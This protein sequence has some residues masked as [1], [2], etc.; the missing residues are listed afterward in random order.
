MTNSG[1][2]IV[3]V[4]HSWQYPAI[5]EYHAFKKVRE[6]CPARNGVVYFAFPWATLIDRIDKG[7]KDKDELLE[8]L[9]SFKEELAKFDVV[10]SVCQ[11]IRMLKHLY[12]FK[13]VGITTV[14]WSHATIS[15]LSPAVDEGVDILPFPLYPTQVAYETPAWE[16]KKY[17]FSFVGA[18]ANKWYLTESR[19]IIIDC[20]SDS[21]GGLVIG[22]DSWH[23]NNVVYKTQIKGEEQTKEEIEQEKNRSE[24]YLQVML[25]TKYALCPSGSGPN[26]IRLWECV[27][28][29]VVPVILADDY[30]VPGDISLWKSAAFFI[31]EDKASIEQLP[32]TLAKSDSK[33]LYEDKL[34]ALRL[35]KFKYGRSSFI[36]DIISFVLEI[37]APLGDSAYALLASKVTGRS[38]AD[39]HFMLISLVSY[40]FNHSQPIEQGLGVLTRMGFSLP[41]GVYDLETLTNYLK[42]NE[43]SE[44]LS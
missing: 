43:N 8:E 27:E 30:K 12:L 16:E 10:I 2:R 11:H 32:E 21:K 13:D 19:N 39:L 25:D 4:D 37:P 28:M 15:S 5:T 23:Y 7:A 6:L 14:F 24:E 9:Y 44:V 29:G 40:Y 36:T 31:G 3:G 33:D 41:D 35:L 34:N 42:S 38:A 26:S 20:L 1:I 17:L 18:R 22:R